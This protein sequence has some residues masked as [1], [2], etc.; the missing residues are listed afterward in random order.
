MS[1][2]QWVLVGLVLLQLVSVIVTIT[3]IGKPRK[4]IEA[5]FAATSFVISLLYVGLYVALIRAL[6]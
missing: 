6:S 3:N 2:L 4:P 1:A 5:S